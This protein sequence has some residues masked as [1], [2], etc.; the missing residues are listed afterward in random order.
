V[1]APQGSHAL[2]VAEIIQVSALAADYLAAQRHAEV[3]AG[4]AQQIRHHQGES[5]ALRRRVDELERG[6]N[7]IQDL[8]AGAMKE[9]TPSP[10]GPVV[11][12]VARIVERVLHG[13]AQPAGETAT[14]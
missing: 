2:A 5:A 11:E 8:T 4:L 13:E 12:E 3:V 6:M 10:L 1:S 14:Q 9:A 7:D